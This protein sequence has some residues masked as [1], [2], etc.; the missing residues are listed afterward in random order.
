MALA[1]A[2]GVTY[3]N[4]AVLATKVAPLIG[5][6]LV[7]NITC[8]NPDSAVAYIQFFDAVTADVT[9]GTT[10]P[11]FVLPMPI[12]GGIDSSLVCPKAF[13]HGIVFAATTTATGLT[14]P[15][16]ASILSF[17]YVGG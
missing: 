3:S 9:I 14:A 1:Q 16:T 12:G 11:Y 6:F 8:F 15:G 10:T 7:F 17:D 5:S 13:H 2:G 4:L